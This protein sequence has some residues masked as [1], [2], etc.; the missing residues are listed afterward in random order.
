MIL[1][2]FEKIRFEK[3]FPNEDFSLNPQGNYYNIRT[4]VLAEG[5]KGAINNLKNEECNLYFSRTYGWCLEVISTGQ[6]VQHPEFDR[7]RDILKWASLNGYVITKEEST[8]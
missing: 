8:D 3:A 5:W 4:D 1:T 2:P 6:G 7:K